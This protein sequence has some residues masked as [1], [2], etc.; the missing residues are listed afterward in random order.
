LL[1]YLAGN[2]WSM[3]RVYLGRM[4][5]L[6]FLGGGV[7]LYLYFLL[8]KKRCLIGNRISWANT[9]LSSYMPGAWDFLRDR[10]RAGGW[11]GLNLTI[12]LALFIVAAFSFGQIVEDLID[13][14]TLFYLDFRIQGLAEGIINPGV[15]RFMVDITNLGGVY[16]VLITIGI[17][18]S[19]LLHKKVGGT[20]FPFFLQLV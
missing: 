1:G 9:K 12:A 19:Y 3:I 18:F 11:Y 8:T 5:I 7:T 16:A 13:R 15:T 2:S 10:F 4:G 6:A 14:E 20:F 17:I